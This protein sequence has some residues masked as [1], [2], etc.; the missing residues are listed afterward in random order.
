MVSDNLEKALCF[1][2]I[3]DDSAPACPPIKQVKIAINAGATMVQ[4]RNK[5]F[6]SRFIGEATGIRDLCRRHGIPFIINDN[7]SLARTVMADGVHLGQEDDHPEIARN[8]LGSQAIIGM[9]V[10]DME[11]LENTDLSHCSYI[12]TGAV[13]P[14]DTKDNKKV[15]GLPGLEAVIRQS[16]VPVVA[17]GGISSTNASSCFECGAAGVAV[18]SF[19]SRADNPLANALAFGSACGCEKR[20]A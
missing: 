10:S 1:Y 20:D 13:F 18:I 19:I 17:I 3:T 6:S 2:F 15:C 5:S 16:P 4:Y 14:T 9:S 8:L 12:G 11:E 7:I